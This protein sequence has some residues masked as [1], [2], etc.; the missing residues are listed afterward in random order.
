MITHNDGSGS[1]ICPDKSTLLAKQTLND[2][3]LA[4]GCRNNIFDKNDLK[5][6]PVQSNCLITKKQKNHLS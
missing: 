1:R 5:V 4:F 6:W 3:I 2:Q